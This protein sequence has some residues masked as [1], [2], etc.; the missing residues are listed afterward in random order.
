MRMRAAAVFVATV[1][2]AAAA[3][4]AERRITLHTPRFVVQPRSDREI[5]TAVRIPR[6]AP[7]DI[8]GMAIDNRGGDAE[9]SSHHFLAYVY[10]GPDGIIPEQARHHALDHSPFGDFDRRLIGGAQTVRK[11]LRPLPG[12]ALRLDAVPRAPGSRKTDVWI[13][14]N[15]HWRTAPTVPAGRRS[16]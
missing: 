14:L 5:V 2:L 3:A 8:G 1:V 6:R 9:F 4:R 13:V 10:T 7:L 16:R 11:I 12:L 15:S